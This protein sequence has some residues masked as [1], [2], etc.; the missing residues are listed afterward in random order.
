MIS[1]DAEYCMTLDTEGSFAGVCI[2][3]QQ[4]LFEKNNRVYTVVIMN[5]E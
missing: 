1:Q 4:E 3:K 5:D 2:A